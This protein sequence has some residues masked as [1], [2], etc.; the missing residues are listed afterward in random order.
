MPQASLLDFWPYP[1]HVAGQWWMDFSIISMSLGTFVAP[2]YLALLAVVAFLRAIELGVSANHQA[3]LLAENGRQIQEPLYPLMVA[4]HICLLFGSALEIWLGKRPFV[5]VLGW[6]MLLL[7]GCCLAGR[8]WVWWS[9][10]E[11]WNTH[12]VT[13]TRPIIDTGPYRYVRHPNYT[14]VIIEMFAL[15]LVH[16]AYVTASICSTLNAVVLWRRIHQEEA[17]L[18]ARPEYATRMGTKPRFLPNFLP[19]LARDR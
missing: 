18:F 9:L 17:A 1:A 13:S 11:Q 10:G 12:I 7:L 19:I 14:I 6:S 8:M 5:P 16:S 3:R 15:P 2:G 4:V